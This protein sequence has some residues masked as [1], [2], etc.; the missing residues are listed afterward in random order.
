VEQAVPVSYWGKDFIVV[1]TGTNFADRVRVTSLRDSCTV[2][3]N[4]TVVSLLNA[5][6]TYE[7]TAGGSTAATYIH[8]SQP[9][10]VNSYFS[11]THTSSFGDPSMVTI[12]PTEQMIRRVTFA[13]F[14]TQYTTSHYVVVVTRTA[15]V[16]MLLLDGVSRASSFTVS[17]NN[18]EY[19]YAKIY[20][21]AGSHTLESAGGSGFTAYAFGM[22]NHES[23]GYLLGSN[24]LD[25]EANIALDGQRVT[26]YDTVDVCQ[27]DTVTITAYAEYDY[28]SLT[29]NVG[30][31]CYSDDTVQKSF[32]LPG[33]YNVYAVFRQTDNLCKNE[34]D[35]LFATV[36]VIANDTVSTDYAH[37]GDS[38]MWY[39]RTL[40]STGTYTREYTNN[41]GCTTT[42]F[43][44]LTLL[45]DTSTTLVK[46][47]CDS[48][49][50]E[51]S[52]YF[53]G[54]TLLVATY[55]AANGCDSTVYVAF[56]HYP[57]YEQTIYIHLPPNDTLV[58][59]DGLTYTESSD[60][61][62][63][64]LHSVNGCDST[65]HLNL[66]VDHEPPVLDTFA[67]W[68]PNAFTPD[69]K[70]NNRFVI[71]SNKITYMHVY[72]Y[73]RLGLY[74]TDF[75]GLNEGWDGTY[76][77]T[78]CKQ[79]AYVYHIKYTTEGRPRYVQTKTGTVTL[80]R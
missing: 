44:T 54:D 29:M 75:D 48:V 28:D 74:V 76:R 53:D 77:G 65:V 71:K 61:T 40:D 36:R 55:T 22:G 57:S 7:Y 33:V 9:S 31:V 63:V 17:A 62:F 19:S 42:E 51:G 68:V 26:E 3:K 38:Y 64:V 16:G 59:I 58:W 20:V 11:S 41:I 46:A 52:Y 1:N 10:M 6:E 50:Y 18:P 30:G 66:V 70:T 2:T 39:E 21:T 72:I 69:E 4:G 49:E 73:N 78:K 60:S 67:L 79:D 47:G 37:C 56:K 32:V 43:F 34:Y 23:Y 25:L 80:L 15:D 5:G 14:N 8:T 24:M 12:S 35:T 45:S 27:G 13:S